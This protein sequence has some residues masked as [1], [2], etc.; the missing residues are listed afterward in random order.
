MWC[1]FADPGEAM[2]RS[3]VENIYFAHNYKRSGREMW[4][5]RNG[6]FLEWGGVLFIG[7]VDIVV[8]CIIY[9]KPVRDIIPVNLQNN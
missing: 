9:G 3:C 8:I 4:G 5:G 2:N 7:L 6:Y 1:W